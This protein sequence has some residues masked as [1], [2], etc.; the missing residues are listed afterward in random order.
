M[1]FQNKFCIWFEV[2]NV[3]IKLLHCFTLLTLHTML[4]LHVCRYILLKMDRNWQ[5]V[6]NWRVATQL[7]AKDV[8]I[9]VQHAK[10]VPIFVNSS[11][12]LKK[13]RK[14]IGIYFFFGSFFATKAN[15]RHKISHH[16]FQGRAKN[17]Y[18]IGLNI[19]AL[20]GEGF[21]NPCHSIRPQNLGKKMVL[22]G[23]IA[24]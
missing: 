23:N 3:H 1:D 6:Q 5:F 7:L 4:T 10:G 24:W 8:A 17:P 14:K 9:N 20:V 21:K 22:R 16:M 11:S 2:S 13:W 12:Y 19:N 18:Q 15:L